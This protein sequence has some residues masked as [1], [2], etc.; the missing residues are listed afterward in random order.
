M[1]RITIGPDHVP[2]AS[3]L[4]AY[5]IFVYLVSSIYQQLYTFEVFSICFKA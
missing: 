1:E 3:A 4:L 5:S 2:V